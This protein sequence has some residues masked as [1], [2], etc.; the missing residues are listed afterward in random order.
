MNKKTLYLSLPITGCEEESID[1]AKEAKF[2]YERQG[3]IVFNPHS[4]REKLFIELGRIPTEPEIMGE[5]LKYLGNADAMILFPG[6]QKS[7]GCQFKIAFANSY[8]IPIYQVKEPVKLNFTT[9]ISNT[10]GSRRKDHW[11]TQ[12]LHIEEPIVGYPIIN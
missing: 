2:Y 7:Q 3:F 5:D 12:P 1:V 4:I 8:N 10:P 6:W 11:I 9:K